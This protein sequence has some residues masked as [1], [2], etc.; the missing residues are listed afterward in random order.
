MDPTIVMLVVSQLLVATAIGYAT[1]VEVTLDGFV[2]FLL[3]AGFGA[4]VIVYAKRSG[5]TLSA[6][7]L[8]PLWGVSPHFPS[9]WV[10]GQYESRSSYFLRNKGRGNNTT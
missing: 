6:P 5:W 7:L 3:C 1:A 8:P 2:T 4:L 9:Y 10:C